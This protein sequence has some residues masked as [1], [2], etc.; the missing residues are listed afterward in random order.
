LTQIPTSA[1]VLQE[2]G[3]DGNASKDDVRQF[4]QSARFAE[5][6]G[7]R[8]NLLQSLQ[9]LMRGQNHSPESRRSSR[10]APSP[11]QH[12]IPFESASS[13][14]SSASP[15][16]AALTSESPEPDSAFLRR[17]PQW[18]V[19]ETPL[20]IRP[21]PTAS[22]SVSLNSVDEHADSVR[23]F[24]HSGPAMSDTRSMHSAESPSPLRAS[25]PTSGTPLYRSALGEGAG[26]G[27][28]DIQ[29]WKA[30]QEILLSQVLQR[31]QE[32]K[33]EMT[34]TARALEAELLWL[35]EE[36]RSSREQ[37]LATRRRCAVPHLH[38]DRLTSAPRPART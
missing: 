22:P 24:E 6:H 14:P 15:A 2:S 23:G 9:E 17:G 27:S 32:K 10:Q 37:L 21:T 33:L 1:Q 29:T 5:L 13:W 26:A 4:L 3:L 38:R 31:S 35:D 7:V 20:D 11:L 18:N 19:P 36:L 8:G 25:P 30:M 28:A 16:E 12:S 34:K